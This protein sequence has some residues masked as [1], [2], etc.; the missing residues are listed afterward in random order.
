MTPDMM[1]NLEAL[2]TLL[3]FHY[4]LLFCRMGSAIMLMP[5]IGE[6]FV[7]IP[8]RLV[9]ALFI[10]L[11]IYMPLHG[12]LPPVPSSPLMLTALI[13]AEIMVGV[14][15]GAMTRLLMG[16]MHMTGM[17]IALQSSLASAVFF[18]P[19]QGS[20]GSVIGTFLTMTALTLLFTSDTHHLI[21]IGVMESYMKFP[22]GLFPDVGDFSNFAARL[23]TDG[24]LTA[25]MI[26]GPVL[27]V[28]FFMYLAAGIMSRLMPT[29]QIFFVIMPIQILVSFFIMMLTLS[30]GMM[31]YLRYFQ[32]VLK[33]FYT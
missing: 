22:V 31:W 8:V 19:N 7:P 17:F 14:F 33:S 1:P 20:Q 5:G 24:F 9:L 27:V 15:I 16:V 10:S 26:A 18:D 11:V 2:T 30:A 32:D 4:L 13:T 3:V 29:M 23:L 28:T 12:K 6:V 21:L 25:L